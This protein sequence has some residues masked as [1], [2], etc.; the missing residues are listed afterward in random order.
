M[1]ETAQPTPQRPFDPVLLADAY[2][3]LIVLS[4][5]P[6]G[7]DGPWAEVGLVR[8]RGAGAG[9]TDGLLRL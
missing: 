4:V 1:L 6:F 9:R 5:T 2:P 8:R 3:R 7:Q